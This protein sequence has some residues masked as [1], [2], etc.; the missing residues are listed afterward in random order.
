MYSYIYVLELQNYSTAGCR[1]CAGCLATR[2]ISKTAPYAEST[3]SFVCILFFPKIQLP[4]VLDVPLSDEL[5]K[6]VWVYLCVHYL[7]AQECVCIHTHHAHTHTNTHTHTHALRA[8]AHTHTYK[9]YEH[10]RCDHKAFNCPTYIHVYK[11]I[12]VHIHIYI[13]TYIYMHTY[14]SI[15]MYFHIHT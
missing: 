11:H 1:I 12:H 15:Y 3:R 8:R 10:S 5:T 6:N 13:Y 4:F 9:H 2:S 14:M 7:Y